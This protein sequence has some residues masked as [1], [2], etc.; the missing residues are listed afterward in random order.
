MVFDTYQVERVTSGESFIG[1]VWSD[2]TSFCISLLIF[3]LHVDALHKGHA[4][5][6]ACILFAASSDRFCPQHDVR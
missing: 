3:L 1:Q 6:S 5:P 2:F 4:F